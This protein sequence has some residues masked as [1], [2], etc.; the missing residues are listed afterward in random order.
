M[1]DDKKDDKP[2]WLVPVV[3][4]VVVVMGLGALYLYNKDQ[5]KNAKTDVASAYNQMKMAGVV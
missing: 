5:N 3:V 2:K 4:V 1:A